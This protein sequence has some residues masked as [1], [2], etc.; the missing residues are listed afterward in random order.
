MIYMPLYAALV[1]GVLI[2]LQTGLKLTVGTYRGVVNKG[3]GTEGDPKL[4]RLARRH[5]NMAENAPIFIA[6][7]A[8]YELFFGQT[9][10]AFWLAA[11]FVFARVAHII[12]FSN[13]AG[14]H[15]EDTSGGKKIFV[16]MRM[17]GAFGS[18]ITSLVLGVALLVGAVPFL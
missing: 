16:A 2:V 6:V 7:L 17:I 3:L 18:A 9:N 5:A 12:A 14:S 10:L 4:A 1:G 8:I 11:I 15:L 13:N